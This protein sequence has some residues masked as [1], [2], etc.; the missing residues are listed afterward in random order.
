M[1]IDHASRKLEIVTS[2]D[3]ESNAKDFAI[4]VHRTLIEN[5]VSKGE[6][7]GAE[8]PSGL[9]VGH[10]GIYISPDI[11]FLIRTLP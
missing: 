4:K 10:P 11:E 7:I 2:V 5:G 9:S 8:N 6:K 1:T 3:V